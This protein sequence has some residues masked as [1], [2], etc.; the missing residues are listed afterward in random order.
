MPNYLK[1]HERGNGGWAR[2]KV[3]KVKIMPKKRSASGYFYSIKSHRWPKVT[4]L[5]ETSNKSLINN[6][7]FNPSFNPRIAPCDNNII[8]LIRILYF[9]IQITVNLVNPCN[10]ATETAIAIGF[11]LTPSQ[12]STA[13]IAG[14]KRWRSIYLRHQKP[15]LLP[16]F[17]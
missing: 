9:Y 15:P 4:K 6:L 10:F 2:W 5:N 7:L 14:I 17:R 8:Y 12:N 16:D 3:N 11:S 13:C 1:K